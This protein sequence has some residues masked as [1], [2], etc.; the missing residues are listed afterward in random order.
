[1][2]LGVGIASVIDLQLNL[3]G[4]IIV[5][6]ATNAWALPMQVALTHGLRRCKRSD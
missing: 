3:L 6:P 1:M 5:V 2:V 4:S